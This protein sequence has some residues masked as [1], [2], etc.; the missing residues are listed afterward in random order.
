ML[1]FHLGWGSWLCAC[2]EQMCSPTRRLSRP[3]RIA[4]TLFTD[5]DP[6]PPARRR[7]SGWVGW[8]LLLVAL[9]GAV[10]VALLPAPYVIEQP[11]PVYDVLGDVTVN[12]DQVPMIQI[13]MEETFPTE[14]S[15]DM[16]TVRV[17]GSPDSLP[18]WLDVA[19]AYLDPSRAIVPVEE[20]YPPGV[21][22]EQS[23]EQGKVD[24]ANSQK[25]AI[26]AALTYLGN[27]VPSTLSVAEVQAGGPSDGLLEVGDII[28]TINGETFPDVTGLRAAIAD[29]GVS[30]PAEVTVLRAG[31][32]TTLRINPE[33]STG[34]NP[35]PILGI[36]VASDYDFPF[37]VTIQLENVGGPSAGMMFALGIVDKLTPGALNGGEAV[38]GT[39][40]ISSTGEVG[41]IGGIRQKMWG[42][43]SAGAHWFLAPSSNCDEVTGH[44]PGGLTVLSVSTLD[45]AMTALAAI[46]SDGSTAGLP[47]CPTK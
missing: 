16:L 26:A 35:A 10:V 23:T 14:G 12:G 3:R 31:V 46:R 1:T 7:A 24:M 39:G 41:P 34:D 18:N 13:P 2:G 15:L 6:D 28:E 29:N 44:I 32:S 45:D 43:R 30:Q 19:T 40:T 37:T 27:E 11:G 33:L 9:V 21:T 4:L 5:L 25:E 20:I 36:V 47:T 38:A 22:S 17:L 42:A 8:T